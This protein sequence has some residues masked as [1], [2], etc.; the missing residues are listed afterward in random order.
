MLQA[1]KELTTYSSDSSNE[2]ENIE[3][4]FIPINDD[5]NINITQN[6]ST[7][8]QNNINTIQEQI[9]DLQENITRKYYPRYGRKRLLPNAQEDTRNDVVQE[10]VQKVE[11]VSASENEFDLFCKSLAVQLNKMPLERALLC[12]EKLQSI[13]TQERLYQIQ[14]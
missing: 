12:Q 1:N 7:V 5:A 3:F 4:K 6:N 13:M 8:A 14:S 2:D 9:N 10:K 11:E